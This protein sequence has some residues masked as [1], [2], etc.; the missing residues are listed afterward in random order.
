MATFSQSQVSAN[1][2]WLEATTGYSNPPA[3][4][5]N[6]PASAQQSY[7]GPTAHYRVGSASTGGINRGRP[8][9]KGGLPNPYQSTGNTWADR[10]NAGNPSSMPNPYESSNRYPS[11]PTT[12]P[13][14]PRVRPQLNPKPARG[15]IAAWNQAARALPKGM[16]KLVLSYFR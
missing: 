1:Y 7:V 15:P 12:V 6:I 2:G 9:P 11:R 13:Q 5:S 16:D 14:P 10:P 4:R 3:A 8:L